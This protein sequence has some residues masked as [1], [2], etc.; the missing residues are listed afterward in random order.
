MKMRIL[1]FSL[2]FT[3]IVGFSQDATIDA[4]ADTVLCSP[5]C[6]DLEATYTGGG[7]TTDYT[8]AAIPYAADPYAGTVRVLSDDATTGA[9]AIGFDF[10]F[11]GSTY[12]NFYIS[13]NGWLGFSGGP[14]TW[15]PAAIPSVVASVPKNCVMGPWQDLNPSVT[16]TIQYQV[17]GTAPFR[18]LVVSWEAVAFFS[19]T[20][21][22]NTQQIMLF[23]TTNVIENHIQTKLTCPVWAGGRAV[24]GVHNAAGTEAVVFPGRNNTVWTATNHAVRYTPLGDPIIEWYEGPILLGT[25]PTISVCPGAPITYEARLISCS[26]D[27]ATDEV[28][29]DQICCEPPV[30][31]HTDVSCFGGCDGTAN[32]EA[33]GVAPFTYL[34]DDPGAQTTATATGLC[35]GVYEVTVTDALGCVETGEVEVLEPEELTGMVTLVNLVSCFG[36]TDGSGTVEGA[37]GTG[38]LTYDIGDGPMPT[39]EFT[40]LPPGDHIVTITDENGCTIEVPL[41]IVSPEL[42]EPVLVGTVNVTCNGGDDGELTVDATG[43]ITPYE[44]AIDGG[45]YGP[46]AT[47]TALTAGSYDIDI[48]DDNGCLTTI[49]VIIDEPT[50]LTL[51]LVA[52]VDATCIGIADG[53]VEVIGGGGTGVLE[54]SIDGGAFGPGST[55]D[56]ISEGTYTVTVK[57]ENDCETTL[58]ITIGEP[59][60]VA[61][62]EIVV[63]ESCLGDC[64][65]SIDLDAYDGFAP[66]TYSIDDCATSDGLGSYAGLCAGTYD[67]CVADANGCE[68]NNTVTVLDGTAPADATI[69]PIGPFCIND[70]AVV[71]SA[72]SPGGVYTGTGVVGG[73]FDP[74]IAGVGTHTITNTISLGCGDVATLDVV[75]NPLPVVSFTT[76]VN[77]GCE[78]LSVPFINTGDVGVDCYWDFGDGLSSTFCGSVNHTY[79]NAGQYDISYTIIDANGCTSTST[80]YDYIDVY[81]QPNA[82]FRFGPQPATTINT[83]INFTDMSTGADSWT[84]TFGDLG[85]SNDQNPEFFFPEIPGNYL[86]DLAVENS[87]GCVDSTQ[88][89]VIISEQLLIFVP[90][91]ITPDGDLYNEVFKPYFNGIDIYDYTL[92]IYNRWGEIMFVSHDVTVGWNGTYGGEIVPT[93][94]YVWHINTQE[95]TSDKKLEFHGHVTLLK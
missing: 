69:T 73:M 86:V 65:G 18:R 44:F 84:W 88:Q 17:L 64:L 4:G 7:N 85:N 32:A 46:D 20:G 2:F 66:Y 61:V 53:T 38:V 78:D 12:S 89:T 36:L 74:G 62:D 43:G 8:V 1:L 91:T 72:V 19:C 75:V 9:I 60:P 52:T 48:R 94:V 83:E 59:I 11:Y 49:T 54:Y 42:L 79:D 39:G 63:G 29:V 16:G 35:A 47:F 58:D 90:N 30:M 95:V 14:G 71:L 56:G 41:T 34:W 51:D 70:A 55:F 82:I 57:D 37:G 50:A 28:F 92:T 3:S 67:V 10:C 27:V 80:M 23:E 81:P 15:S 93:G 68:Y 5:D 31:T 13:S 45:A 25:G 40:D 22:L 24:Q 6:V 33:I 76:T 26:G 21:T 77:S 87:F